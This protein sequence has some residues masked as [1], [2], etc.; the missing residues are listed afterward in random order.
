[1]GTKMSCA[2]VCYYGVQQES[3]SNTSV[4]P[5]TSHLSSLV[6]IVWKLNCTLECV[7]DLISYGFKVNWKI[8]LPA[9]RWL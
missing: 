2:P 7:P 6:T 5:W 1:M 3:P 4:E 9:G 8:T